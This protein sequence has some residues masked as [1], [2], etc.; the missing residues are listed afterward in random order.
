MALRR[1]ATGMWGPVACALRFRSGAGMPAAAPSRFLAI[2][3]N[4][5]KKQHRNRTL[6]EAADEEAFIMKE[7]DKVLET[8]R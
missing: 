3:R 2:I 7:L 1:L 8:L 5:A 6:K 4:Q